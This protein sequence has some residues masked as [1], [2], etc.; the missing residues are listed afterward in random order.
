MNV[1]VLREKVSRRE[2]DGLFTT[3]HSVDMG[4]PGSTFSVGLKEAGMAET[5][6]DRKTASFLPPTH[7]S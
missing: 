7:H 3:T 5:G 6:R 4:E 2:R 1:F